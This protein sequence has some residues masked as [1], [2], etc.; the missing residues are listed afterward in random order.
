M[1]APPVGLSC[2]T[3]QGATDGEDA[4]ALAVGATGRG[5]RGPRGAGARP[6][7]PA[8]QV[9]PE[10]RGGR[11]PGWR[12]LHAGFWAA[13]LAQP[14]SSPTDTR[15]RARASPAWLQ[16]ERRWAWRGDAPARR[17]GGRG[18]GFGEGGGGGRGRALAVGRLRVRELRRG[19]AA[20]RAARGVRGS[21]PGKPRRWSRAEPGAGGVEKEN[22]KRGG[23]APGHG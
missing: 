3:S 1:F 23:R 11:D 19:Q 18:W 14:H 9:P 16:S 2:E 10:P 15:A 17:W 4:E 22:R 7:A 13:A 8:R 21:V 6:R 20:A 5:A 12:A